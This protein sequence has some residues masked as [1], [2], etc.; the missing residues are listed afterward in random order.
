MPLERASPTTTFRC[1]LM[2]CARAMRALAPVAR[3][4]QPISVPKNQYSAPMSSAVM[5][6][7]SGMG[8]SKLSSRTN[9]WDTTRS[10][11]STLMAWFDF[12]PMIRRFTE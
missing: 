12:P 11:L 4:P 8:F 2:P 10:N 9:R 7:S 3:M 1:V 6:S 5:T